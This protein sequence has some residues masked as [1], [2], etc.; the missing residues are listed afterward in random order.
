MRYSFVIIILAMLFFVGCGNRQSSSL[1]ASRSLPLSMQ[2]VASWCQTGC[3]LVSYAEVSGNN[4]IIGLKVPAGRQARFNV[5][6]RS[7]FALYFCTR[8]QGDTFS[9]TSFPYQ[10]GNYSLIL[11]D[12]HVI[13]FRPN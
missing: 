13:E 7:G 12:E 3:E 10:V 1:Q 5:P 2:V 11:T 9:C 6:S 4:T 8:F